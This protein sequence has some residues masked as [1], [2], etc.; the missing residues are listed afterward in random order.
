MLVDEAV[1]ICGGDAWSGGLFGHVVGEEDLN[2][3]ETWNKRES[4]VCEKL[5]SKLEK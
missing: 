2:A 1:E 3:P 4:T 5:Q